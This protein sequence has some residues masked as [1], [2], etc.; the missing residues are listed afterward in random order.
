MMVAVAQHD[1]AITEREQTA[2]LAEIVTRFG[3]SEKQAAELLARARWIVRELP[4]ADA[5]L[6]KLRPLIQRKCSPDQKREIV[7]MLRTVAAVE[8]TPDDHVARVIDQLDRDI[9]R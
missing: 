3:A 7:A 4:D 2:I 1:G 8:W 6:Q 9:N 5:S